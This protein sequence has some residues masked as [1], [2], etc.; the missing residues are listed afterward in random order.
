V[1]VLALAGALLLSGSPPA[2]SYDGLV[3]RGLA[4]GR[5]GR[6]E[7]AAVAFDAA[8]LKDPSRPEA[9][10]ERGGLRFLEKRY[11]EAARDLEISLRLR[12]DAYTRDLLGSALHL[13]GRSDEGL[14]VWNRLGLPLAGD[15]QISGLAHTLDR[16]A[17]REVTVTSGEM[18][19][20][21]RVR[22]TRRRLS[23]IDAFDGV[24]VR[25]VPRGDGQADVEVALV[26]RHGLYQGPIDLAAHLGTDLLF[27]R[28]RARYWNIAGSGISI[29]GQYRWEENRP[30]LSLQVEWPRPLGLG[31]NLRVTAARGQQ[32]YD[33]G[34]PLLS[35]SHGVDVSV[36]RVLG[37]ATV[38]QLVLRIR[39]RSFSRP[40]PD[41]RP[42]D[43]VGLEA[44]LDR[45]LVETH[46]HRLDAGLRLYHA[47]RGVGSDVEFSR[48]T[49][50]ISYRAFLL[51]PEGSLIERSVL[52]ARLSWGLGGAGMPIDEMF[53]PGG[54]PEMELPLRAHPQTLHGT[55]GVSP[56][57]RGL[58]L[59]NLEW[60]RRLF[61]SALVQVAAVVF[62]DGAW[63]S[64]MPG[65]AGL[66]SLQDVGVGVRIGLGGVTILRFDYGHGLS[67]G[68]NAF[69]FGLNQVF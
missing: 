50:A 25:P 60:R 3:S 38:G 69:F 28:V 39:D 65:S 31:A 17:R 21:A 13:A 46:R 29:G 49:A 32:L 33:L 15:I 62:H 52:A 64:R 51:R 18:L 48:A 63:V 1:I 43:V 36:R 42:G 12:E 26:E 54:S 56:I 9:W 53:A 4:R 45:T 22:E 24:T 61:R 68:E 37:P 41:A 20:L 10:A 66:T 23:E 27:E 14:A 57:G 67:D 11:D 2:D 44:G 16:V 5:E 47:G 40:D 8:I 34:Q 30:L 58:A 6:F 7:D 55:L 35:R 19:T 59:T